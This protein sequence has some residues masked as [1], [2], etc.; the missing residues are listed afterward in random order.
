MPPELSELLDRAK[1]ASGDELKVL[2]H[3]PREEILTAVLENP[4]CGETHIVL[5]LERLDISPNLIEAI[6]R[7]TKWNSSEAVRLRLACHPR[8]PKRAALAAVRQL[9]LFDLVRVSLLPSAPADIK[10]I[11]E[12]TIISRVSHLPIGQKLTLA[13]RG[14]SRVAGAL[15]AEGH[16]RAVELA[17]NNPFLTESQI[18]KVLAKQEVPERTV[19]AIARHSKWVCRQTVRLALL[20]NKHTPA[21]VALEFLPHLSVRDLTDVSGLEDL[22]PHLRSY[23]QEEIGRRGKLQEHPG[24]G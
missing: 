19:A 10:R 14:P 11:A 4:H 13:R 20:R 12:E 9:Y 8:T 3:E 17:L 15:L 7:Q 21:A 1:S 16:A 5:L 24:R 23:I 6:S 18:L 22:A 2:L